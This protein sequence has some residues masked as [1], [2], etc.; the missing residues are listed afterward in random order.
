MQKVAESTKH[1]THRGGHVVPLRV[2]VGVFVSLAILTFI[3]VEVSKFDFGEYSLVIALLIAVM[4]ASLVVLFFMHLLWDKP[5][6]AIIF[7]GCLIFV[8]L[9]IGLTLMD[10]V[11][12]YGSEYQKQ[13]QGIEH[14]PLRGGGVDQP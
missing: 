9:F 14:K 6:N 2:L 1:V 8:G 10:T 11:Q 7:V 3:T 13:A 5:F 12:N 4:K